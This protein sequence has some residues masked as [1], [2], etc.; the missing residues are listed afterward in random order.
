MEDMKAPLIIFCYL[1]ASVH[2]VES[3]IEVTGYVGGSALIRCPYDKGYEGYPKYLCRGSC[4]VGGKV[5]S[6]RTG[7]TKAVNGRFSLHDDTTARV[8]TVTITG[9]TA[10]D[11]GQYWCSI[12]VFIKKDV[13]TEVALKVSQV[14]PPSPITNLLP[15]TEDHS[16]TPPPQSSTPPT[17]NTFPSVPETTISQSAAEL[18]EDTEDSVVIL[19]LCA[20]GIVALATV[21]GMALALYY[22]QKRKKQLAVTGNAAPSLHNSV[23]TEEPND[24]DTSFE[25][26]SVQEAR[27]SVSSIYCYASDTQRPSVHSLNSTVKPVVERPEQNINCNSQ[28]DIVFPDYSNDTLPEGTTSPTMHYS[29]RVAVGTTVD[30]LSTPV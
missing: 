7:Q 8:F 21:F 27:A 5:I 24:Y 4:V 25:P 29:N 28:E 1:L 9:L 26:G 14:P 6:V 2:S 12:Y 30:T 3:V 16:L 23:H 20:V 11:S 15:S 10:K 19:V 13:Y 22:K 18:Q 17:S